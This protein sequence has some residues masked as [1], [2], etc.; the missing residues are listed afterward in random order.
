[1]TGKFKTITLVE[2]ADLDRL[3]QRQ[4]NEYIPDLNSLPKIQDEI[5]KMFDDSELSDSGKWKIH[6]HLQELF[7][8]LVN[9]F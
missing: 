4:I 5:F 1:M 8:I 6:D 7:P 3:R 9:K 2:D